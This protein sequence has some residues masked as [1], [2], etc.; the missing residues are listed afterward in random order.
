M[1]AGSGEEDDIVGAF[2]TI[3]G[4]VGAHFAKSYRTLATIEG[5]HETE[6]L[7][8]AGSFLAHL[9]EVVVQLGN[10]LPEILERTLEVVVGD[11]EMLFDIFL[12]HAVARF[13]GKDG[14]LADNVAR[15]EVLTRIGLGKTC[16]TCHL[17][18]LRHGHFFAQHVEDVVERATYHGFDTE[19]FVTRVDQVV[20]GV[21]DRKTG[22]HVGLEEIFDATHT[23]CTLELCVVVVIARSGNLVGTNDADVVGKQILIE[24]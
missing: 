12:R 3:E 7:A 10:A 14:N 6:H 21:D 8:M 15:I 11:E 16:L 24:A 9:L 22:T 13:A 2:E 5:C 20:D 19:H 4:A 23:G 18:C 1:I 17:D